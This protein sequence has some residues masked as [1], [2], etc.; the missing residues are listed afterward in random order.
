[1][2]FIEYWSTEVLKKKL[3]QKSQLNLALDKSGDDFIDH[4]GDFPDSNYVPEFDDIEINLAKNTE[5]EKST[6]SGY[7]YSFGEYLWIVSPIK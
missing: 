1:M 6:I 2:K 5:L 7:R 4:E 3:I